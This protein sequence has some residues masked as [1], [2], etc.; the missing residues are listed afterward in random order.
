MGILWRIRLGSEGDVIAAVLSA[1]VSR[2]EA[3]SPSKEGSSSAPPAA[4]TAT[5]LTGLQWAAKVVAFACPSSFPTGF[6]FLTSVKA[7]W[8]QHCP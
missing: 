6:N 1:A 4:S 2:V 7:H 5:L 3:T 8:T